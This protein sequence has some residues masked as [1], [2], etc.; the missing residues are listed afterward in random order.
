MTPARRLLVVA[1]LAL[2]TAACRALPGFSETST[3]VII[4][5]TTVP[6]SAEDSGSR[7]II[8]PCSERTIEYHGNTW[9]GDPKS[10]QPVAEPLPPGA[11][12]IKLESQFTRPFENALHLGVIVDSN[13]GHS[14]NSMP[15]LRSLPCAGVPPTP[16]P[17]RPSG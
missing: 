16:T 1:L 14:L 17:P 4:N 9:G 11:Y 5:K 2:A 15:E 13:G 6:V 10:G 12:V 7:R 8:D 3:M